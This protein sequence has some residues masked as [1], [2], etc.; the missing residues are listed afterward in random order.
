[1]SEVPSSFRAGISGRVGPVTCPSLRSR[2]TK[3][4]IGPVVVMY[5]A[6][7]TPGR[8]PRPLSVREFGGAIKQRTEGT[9]PCSRDLSR[10]DGTDWPPLYGLIGVRRLDTA[11][12]AWMATALERGR[13]TQPARSPKLR[14]AKA[15]LR[16]W[17]KPIRSRQ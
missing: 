13:G 3:R 8:W 11:L 16:Q 9:R 1:M 17:E 2:G 12:D 10:N 14:L 7:P 4:S 6:L 15:D 5:P